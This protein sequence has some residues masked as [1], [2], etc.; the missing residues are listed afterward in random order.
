EEGQFVRQPPPGLFLRKPRRFF[1]SGQPIEQPPRRSRPANNDAAP[2]EL[3]A[4]MAFAL[5][6][7]GGKDSAPALWTLPREEL[8]P[9]ALVTTVTEGYERISMHGV[10]PELLAPQAEALGRLPVAV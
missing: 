4:A 9:Q 6:W 10:R 2:D 5:S 8:Q 1:I 3:P 7:S